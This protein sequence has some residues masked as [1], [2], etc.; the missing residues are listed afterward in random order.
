MAKATDLALKI[1]PNAKL[2]NK[3]KR[4]LYDR[5]GK[6]KV[7]SIDDASDL[8]WGGLLKKSNFET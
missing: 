6:M 3:T 2:Y 7:A 4:D 8:T 5:S 1:N